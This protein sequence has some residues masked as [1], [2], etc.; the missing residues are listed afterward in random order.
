M[1]KP[2]FYPQTFLPGI[3]SG[4]IWEIAQICFMFSN[5]YLPWS[6]T[7]SINATGPGLVSTLWGILVFGEIRGVKNYVLFG[8]GVVILIS[9]IICVVLSR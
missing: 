5:T 8:C 1:N 3:V 4:I 6:V 9:G 2:V 7:F